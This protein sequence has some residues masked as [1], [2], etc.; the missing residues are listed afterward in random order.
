M[1]IGNIGS[2]TS[3]NGN[4]AGCEGYG[5]CS[6]ELLLPAMDEGVPIQ[7]ALGKVIRAMAVKEFAAKVK[8]RL[9]NRL[10]K[11]FSLKL[12]L[13]RFDKLRVRHAN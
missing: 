13:A 2:A 5:P 1:T 9:R 4:A 3:S 7:M 12:G 10:L 11:P 6:R 8:W